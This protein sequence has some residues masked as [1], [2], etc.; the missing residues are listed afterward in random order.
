MNIALLSHLASRSAPTG[1]EHSLALLA[2]S[3]A[4]DVVY[5]TRHAGQPIE[6]RQTPS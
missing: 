6:R 3:F 5:L 1:A 2:G 4:V